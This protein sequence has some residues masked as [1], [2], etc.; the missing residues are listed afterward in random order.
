MK[1]KSV[2]IIIFLSLML[3][4]IPVR[5][6]NDSYDKN[7]VSSIYSSASINNLQ[8]TSAIL[9]EANTG[10]ILFSKDENKQIPIASLTKIMSVY[11]VMEA[12]SNGEITYETIVTASAKAHGVEGSSVY[13]NLGEEFT[14][15]E[16]LYA[17]E[18]RSANDATVAVAEA[19]AG[20]QGEF[21]NRM[22]QKA[23]ELGML[24][25]YYRD[26]TGL[27]D[28]GHYSTVKDLS[29]ITKAL[30]TQYPDIFQFSRTL[31]KDFRDKEH[32]DYQYMVNR[33]NLLNYYDGAS[34]LK[35]GFTTAAGYCLVGTAQRGEISLITIVT[36]EPDNNHRV[37]EAA[38]LLDYGFSNF[39]YTQTEDDQKMVG[40]IEVRKGVEKTVETY[41]KGTLRF[42]M[43]KTDIS[44]ISK[45]IIYGM[46][47]LEAPVEKDTVIGKIVY[48]LDGEVLG[49]VE[50][51]T[52]QGMERA[53]FWTLLWRSILSWFGIDW[54][55]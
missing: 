23:T 13:L 30:I 31:E 29:I 41:A 12:I 45:E 22:N 17:I 8:A 34:G 6:S 16:M 9:V 39:M 48:S 18:V 28:A 10:Q 15:R 20:S 37:G 50:V 1:R 49:E 35:T 44:R 38:F 40:S 54:Q 55:K 24:D 33:N 7:E 47:S 51:L 21:V 46:A 52:A 3:M 42:L 53:G 36:G 2:S 27:T 32:R 11:L 26:C 5:A 19:I 43:K 14:L 4:L 25:T